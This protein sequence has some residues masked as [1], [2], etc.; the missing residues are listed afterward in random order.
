MYGVSEPKCWT[1]RAANQRAGRV[2]TSPIAVTNGAET[3]SRSQR[4]LLDHRAM[5]TAAA[6][7]T[8]EPRTPPRI[9]IVTKS[10]VDIASPEKA[11]ATMW[12]A[13]PRN[14]HVARVRY[15]APRTF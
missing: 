9:E 10:A 8:A 4:R 11:T 7:T 2:A 14:R 3:E 5:T 6:P 1:T 13:G 15:Q 12:A